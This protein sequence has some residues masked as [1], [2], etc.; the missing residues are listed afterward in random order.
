MTNCTEL[1]GSL[2]LS[3]PWFL[4][5]R[6]SEGKLLKLF[7]GGRCSTSQQ[8][9]GDR[10]GRQ[11]RRW[12]VIELPEKPSLVVLCLWGGILLLALLRTASVEERVRGFCA[13]PSRLLLSL[14]QVFAEAL[15]SPAL[16]P[17]L[18]GRPSWDTRG[19]PCPQ[20]LRAGSE[21]GDGRPYVAL[22]IRRGWCWWPQVVIPQADS[23]G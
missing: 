16:W 2:K 5:K 14:V 15:S 23:H 17:M 1:L 8:E 10:K 11:G 9:W 22:W 12:C 4:E 19:S 7:R 3:Y 18:P 6:A 13:E 21:W 20:R